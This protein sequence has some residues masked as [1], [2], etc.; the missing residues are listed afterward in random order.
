MT[1]VR[2]EISICSGA[3]WTSVAADTTAAD[4]TDCYALP[5]ETCRIAFWAERCG[6]ELPRGHVVIWRMV[7]GTIT[8]PCGT[9]SLAG[10]RRA[11][12]A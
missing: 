9:T 2:I 6:L 12:P 11:P 3:G 7:G 5:R 4:I 8:M 1:H 10:C